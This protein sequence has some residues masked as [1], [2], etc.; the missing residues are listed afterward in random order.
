[1]NSTGDS[2]SKKYKFGVDY[3]Q[4]IIDKYMDMKLNNTTVFDGIGKLLIAIAKDYRVKGDL[5][6]AHTIALHIVELT[7]DLHY[8]N[9][10]L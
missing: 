2:M 4:D 3:N 10:I 6:L 5:A 7:V 9:I 8:D 1:M